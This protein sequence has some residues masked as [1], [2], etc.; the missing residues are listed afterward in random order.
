[1][2]PL[3]STDVLTLFSGLGPLSVIEQLLFVPTPSPEVFLEPPLPLLPG[4][5]APLSHSCGLLYNFSNSNINL[6]STLCLLEG[7]AFI[8]FLSTRS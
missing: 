8:L 3:A 1:M 2:F 6:D 5:G 4:L 7:I